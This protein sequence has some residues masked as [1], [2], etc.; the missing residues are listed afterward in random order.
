LAPVYSP[1][2]VTCRSAG[3]SVKVVAVLVPGKSGSC[4]A[5]SAVIQVLHVGVA[6]E[7]TECVL[8]IRVK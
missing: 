8:P 2:P 3:A 4:P 7:P 6:G 1:T 5:G